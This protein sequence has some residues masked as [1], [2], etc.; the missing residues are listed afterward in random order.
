MTNIFIANLDFGIT[1]EDLKATFSQF[2]EVS[3]S[4]VVYDNKTKKSKG[5]G[6]VE[7]EDLSQANAA[8][9]AL[10]GMEVNGRVLDVKLATPKDKRPQNM[11][12]VKEGRK[13]SAPR[14]PREPKRVKEVKTSERRVMRPRRKRNKE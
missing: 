3:Y 1:S 10:N 11:N 5:Y 12:K 6:Y 2:G 8:I 13:A 7:M 9:G 14:A 4:H